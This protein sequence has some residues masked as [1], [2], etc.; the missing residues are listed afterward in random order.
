MSNCN[1][2]AAKL[3]DEKNL[4]KFKKIAEPSKKIVTNNLETNK[5][6]KY[7]KSRSYFGLSIKN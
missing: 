6:T 1:K 2:N 7:L 4:L 3:W 5:V